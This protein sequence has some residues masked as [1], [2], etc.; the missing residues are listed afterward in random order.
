MS[1][2]HISQGTF[3][4]SDTKVLTLNDLTINA[5]ES[6]AFVGANGSGKSALARALAGTLARQKGERQCTFPRIA[7]LSFEQLQKLVSDEW[8]RNNTDLLSPDEDD[9]GRTPA[10]IIQDEVKDENRCQKLAQLFGITPLLTR[11]FKYR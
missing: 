10:E 7:H 4:L 8:Q 11:R 6:W 9:T 3:H 5:G 2:L 1:V